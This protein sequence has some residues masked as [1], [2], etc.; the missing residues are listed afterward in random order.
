MMGISITKELLPALRFLGCATVLLTSCWL[1]LKILAARFLGTDADLPGSAWR[2]WGRALKQTFS[3]PLAI[4]IFSIWLGATVYVFRYAWIWPIGA[5]PLPYLVHDLNYIGRHPYGL[6]IILQDPFSKPSGGDIAATCVAAA[7]HFARTLA[8]TPIRVEVL[9]FPESGYSYGHDAR[10]GRC[11]YDPANYDDID[12]DWQK[13]CEAANPISPRQLKINMLLGS[14][15]NNFRK[16][17]GIAVLDEKALQ[18]RVGAELGIDPE[19][20][21]RQNIPLRPVLS[22]LMSE[23]Q[24]EAPLNPERE[25]I[26]LPLR[27]IKDLAGRLRRLSYDYVYDQGFLKSFASKNDQSPL[28][29]QWNQELAT[30]EELIAREQDL[31]AEIKKLPALIREFV[32]SYARGKGSELPLAQIYQII[33][34]E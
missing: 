29:K 9:A 33:Y 4:F 2:K 15:A 25:K 32:Q 31:P 6:S 20:A 14:L 11:V 18:R 1:I 17:S 7:K 24:A 12:P 8:Y 13:S 5:R 3:S 27:Q 16:A 26:L 22:F 30:L 23:P 19:L 34:A 28:F 21:Q 10:L